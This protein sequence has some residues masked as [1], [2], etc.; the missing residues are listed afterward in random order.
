MPADNQTKKIVVKSEDERL[1]YGEVYAPLQID[2]D[3]E[4]MTA[5]EIKKMAHK[6]LMNGLHDK[7]DV[8]HDYKESGCLVVESFIARKNDPDGFIENAWI[9]GVKIIPDELWDQVKKGELNGF[10]FSG[11]AAHNP[12]LVTIT[13]TKK[14]IGTS[15]KSEPGLLPEHNHNISIMFDDDG[16]IVDGIAEEKMGHTHVIQ[17]TTATEINMEHAHRLILIDNNP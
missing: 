6:F 2:T 4:S 17:R 12:S 9:L 1:V 5:I 3:G 8:M 7:I 14:M 10:S 16:R 11:K 13:V 15:E